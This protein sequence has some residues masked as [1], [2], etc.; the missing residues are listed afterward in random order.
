[1]KYVEVF[2]APYTDLEMNPEFENDVLFAK[3]KPYF[4]MLSNARQGMPYLKCPAMTKT[5]QNDFV[6][7]APYDLV[8]TFTSGIRAVNTDRFGQKF[9]DASLRTHWGNLPEGM[10]PI[11]QGVP[12]Y[13]M[14][15]F[16]D[17]EIE[18]TD[19]PILTSK[20]T[21]NAKVMGGA[22]NISKWYRP[23]EVAFEVVDIS[24]PV[25]LEAGEPMCLLR[26]RTP[27]N[28]PVKLTRVEI[29][30]ELS[31]RIKACVKV[32]DK[33]KGLKLEQLYEL[34]AD[35]IELFRRRNKPWK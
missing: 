9:F 14:Y 2:W 12:R 6:I 33:Q 24:K 32:K 10:P 20:F 7:C 18:L 17:V 8:F 28:V 35:C 31:S 5:H 29:T 34:A 4:P 11:V 15:S 21:R 30:P 25:E 26:F 19:L 13:M 27:N 1:M 3:P 16:E 23:F 22:F